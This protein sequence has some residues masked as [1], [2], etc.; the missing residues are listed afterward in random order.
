M[1]RHWP[2]GSFKNGFHHLFESE[3]QVLEEFCEEE[4]FETLG[5]GSGRVVITPEGYGTAFKVARAGISARFGSGRESNYIEAKRWNE[6]KEKPLMPVYAAASDYSWLACPVME[7]PESYSPE[8]DFEEI[9]EEMEVSLETYSEKLCLRDIGEDNIGYWNGDWYWIDYGQP[10]LED[11][12]LYGPITGF[13]HQK[14]VSE[15]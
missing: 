13:S 15:D 6:I 10:K 12:R 8:V 9:I 7:P 11:S 3:K 14:T 2:G 4:S 1:L 5:V